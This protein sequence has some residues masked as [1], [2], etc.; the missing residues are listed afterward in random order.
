MSGA[1]IKDPATQSNYEDISTQHV[2]FDWTI[3]WKNRQFVGSATHTLQAHKSGVNNVVYAPAFPPCSSRDV[4]SYI[5]WPASTLRILSSIE[6]PLRV[7]TSPLAA[8]SSLSEPGPMPDRP[9]H[10]PVRAS[11]YSRC[12]RLRSRYL[13]SED[14]GT[15]R[16]DRRH[17]LLFY[18]ERRHR[19][20]MA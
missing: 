1:F 4:N 16:Q 8:F 2:H 5:D 9:S 11:S 14:A 7:T 6:S 18:Y 20:R 12:L 13:A 10:Y 17:N 19:H 3:D 15:R